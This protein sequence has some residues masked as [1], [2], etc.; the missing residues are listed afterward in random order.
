MRNFLPPRSALLLVLMASV[1][2]A[3]EREPVSR[4]L[5]LS[6]SPRDEVPPVYVAG[7]MVTVFRFRQPCTQAGT[8]MLGWEGRFEPVECA[9]KKVL[10]EP[11]KDLKPED[12]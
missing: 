5:Y 8:K 6:D 7:E 9:G 1:A 3:K 11:L 10:I 2:G 12:R 4:N